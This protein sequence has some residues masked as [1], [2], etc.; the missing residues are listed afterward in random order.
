V[1]LLHGAQGCSFLE[2]VMGV[3]AY[4][5]PFALQ[6]T[7]LFTEEVVM[8]SEGALVSAVERLG[9]SDAELVAVIPT[10]VSDVKGDDVAGAIAG[11]GWAGGL[12]LCVDVPAMPMSVVTVGSHDYEGG[13]QEGFATAVRALLALAEPGPTD[14]RQITVLAGSHLSAADFVEV[15]ET[16]EAFGLRALMVPDL[17]ALDGSRVGLSPL[18]VGGTTVDGLREIGGSSH[19]LVIGP[20]LEEAARELRERFATPYTVCDSAAGRAASQAFL[21][22]LSLLSGDPVPTR[23]ERQH[24]VLVDAMRDAHL[25][26]AEA[27]VAIALESDHALQVATVLD[28]LGARPRVAVVP[29]VT[30][31]THRIPADEV[32][33]GDLS[34]VPCD[35]DLLIGDAR[36]ERTARDRGAAFLEVGVPA[37]KRFGAN[38]EIRIGSRGTTALVDRM[39]ELVFDRQRAAH[40]AS[41]TT[42]H[43]GGP[44]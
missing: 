19:T 35:I 13:L 14:G 37:Y 39:A 2:K 44:R 12:P 23:L 36:A 42:A 27:R 31:A 16:V 11:A 22:T 43:E 17:G 38:H 40:G 8:G 26:F 29:H 33:C 5:E 21:Q 15:R 6:T 3:K 24:R 4:R 30:E 41:A 18:A 25:T 28:E 10:S 9:E 32:V 1:P 20:S 7:K 34:H